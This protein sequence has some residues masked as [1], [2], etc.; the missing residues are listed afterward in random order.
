MRSLASAQPPTLGDGDCEALRDGLLGQPTNTVTSAAYVAA[1][2]WLGGRA[3]ALPRRQRPT[4]VAYAGLVVLTGIG[5]IAYHGPQFRG[6]EMMHDLPIVAAALLGAGV[7]LHRRLRG[8]CALPGFSTGTGVAIGAT[9]AV[10]LASY[11]AGRTSSPLCNPESLVQPHGL[12][13]LAT[14]A[15]VALWGT[16]V[17]ADEAEVEDE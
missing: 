1:G 3:A 5:S 8:R 7:P 9:G 15:A 4:A 6:A 13:H 2:A 14:A 10:A 16:V 12:W 11:A 17:W